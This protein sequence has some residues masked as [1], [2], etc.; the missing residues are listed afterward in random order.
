MES[1]GRWDE[2]RGT[3]RSQP[4][5][6]V[7]ECLDRSFSLLLGLLRGSLLLIGFQATASIG[8]LADEKW[9]CRWARSG[10]SAE[11]WLWLLCGSWGG[12]L[13][14]RWGRRCGYGGGSGDGCLGVE[15]RALFGVH[16]GPY[17]AYPSPGELV[18]AFAGGHDC[19]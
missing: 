8:L 13:C 12:G 16:C 1:G 6:E 18:A 3:Y 10:G 5:E 19:F 2:G 15:D 4:V 7:L 17:V 9:R 14:R 11:S